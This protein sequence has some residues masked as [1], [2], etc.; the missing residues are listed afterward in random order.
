LAV[1]NHYTVGQAVTVQGTWTNK[2]TGVAVDPSDARVDV[3][4]PTGTVTTYTY[5]LGQVTKVST[6]VYTYV[7]DTTATPGRWQYRWWSP[8]GVVT[9]AQ[10]YEFYVDPFPAMLP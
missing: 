6:G 9:T 8:P 2:S 7:I 5:L 10:A 3:V 1:P 4:S